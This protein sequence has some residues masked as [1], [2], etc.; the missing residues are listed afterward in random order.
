MA[1]RAETSVSDDTNEEKENKDNLLF[2][3][4]EKY[5]RDCAYVYKNRKI[6]VFKSK[7]I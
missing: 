3:M 6:K 7:V 1:F 4:R 2:S 5:P